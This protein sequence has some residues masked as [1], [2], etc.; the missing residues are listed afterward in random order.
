MDRK[1]SENNGRF[2]LFLEDKEEDILLTKV[3]GPNGMIRIQDNKVQHYNES[4]QQV[5]QQY[6]NNTPS[7]TPTVSHDSHMPNITNH[8]PNKQSTYYYSHSSR[9]D[10]NLWRNKKR[11]RR[12]ELI[13]KKIYTITGRLCSF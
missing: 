4:E 5:F 10:N 13:T 9:S 12:H 3:G 1:A 8:K 7:S 6:L 11:S 2:V